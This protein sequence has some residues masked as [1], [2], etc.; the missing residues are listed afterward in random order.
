MLEASAEFL[1][2]AWDWYYY[3]YLDWLGGFWIAVVFK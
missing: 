1:G 3:D 2:A